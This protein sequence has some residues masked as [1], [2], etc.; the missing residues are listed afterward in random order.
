MQNGAA[1]PIVK[2]LV[3]YPDDDEEDEMDTKPEVGV[4]LN[5]QQPDPVH[6]D[7]YLPA[8]TP[9]TP[10]SSQTPQTPPERLSE[11]RRREE[12]D[13][14]ELVKLASG[15]KRRNSNHSSPGGAGFLK[16]KKSLSFGSMTGA[17]KGTTTTT[18]Q[19]FLSSTGNVTGGTGPKKIAINLSAATLKSSSA[20]PEPEST[21]VVTTNEKENR[22]TNNHGDEGG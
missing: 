8:E 18:T 20:L 11:K 14:D 21:V 13:E 9:T 16:S 12:D 22:D 4:Q 1:S 19:G 15:S 5:Q 17:D 10:V 3:D 6:H 2:P 7:A